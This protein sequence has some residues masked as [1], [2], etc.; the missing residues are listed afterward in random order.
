MFCFLTTGLP[1]GCV[2]QKVLAAQML[3]D[4]DIEGLTSVYH[5]VKGHFSASSSNRYI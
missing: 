1:E 2:L 3:D 4:L 5:R